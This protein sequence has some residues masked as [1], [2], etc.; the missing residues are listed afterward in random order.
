MDYSQMTIEEGIRA[1][2]QFKTP[3][4]VKQDE[5]Y[6]MK[7]KRDENMNKERFTA[8]IDKESLV[9]H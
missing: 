5:A 7:L 2:G 4:R 1:G 9:L 6:K 3:Q 8:F